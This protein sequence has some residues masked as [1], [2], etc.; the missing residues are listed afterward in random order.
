[1]LIEVRRLRSSKLAAPRQQRGV[2]LIELVVFIVLVSIGL[3][4]LLSV[5][6]QSVVQS[7]DPV[8]RIKAIE[9]AQA[10]M[11]EILARK[12]DENTPTGGIPACDSADGVACAGIAS[13]TDYDD[14]GDYHG[15]SDNSDPRFQVTAQVMLGG[16]DLGIAS[17]RARLIR[18]T[19]SM[20]GLDELTLSAYKVNF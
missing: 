10:L 16:D 2:S 14:V 4:A 1:M 17:S 13:D 9:K 7:V 6:N 12:F 11:D 18:V 20:P 3:G 19:V 8:V 5:F 15:Y